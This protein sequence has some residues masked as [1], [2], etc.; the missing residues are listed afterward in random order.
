ML[1]KDDATRARLGT[2]LYTA[3]E[4]LRA[5]ATLLA[6][7]MPL[8]TGKLW[9]ALAGDALGPLT[10]Q[11]IRD[12]GTWGVLQPGS[13]VRALEPLFPRI[14]EAVESVGTGAA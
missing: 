1:A 14:E 7:V 12:A 9:A 6:P 4:G 3:S 5:L 10:E 13:L 11:R 8:A 2:V